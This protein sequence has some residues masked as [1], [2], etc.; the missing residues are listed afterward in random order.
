MNSTNTNA[1]G[2]D[3]SAMREFCNNRIYNAFPI[4]WKSIIKQVNI[5]ASAGNKSSE[6]ITSKDYVYLPSYTEMT[7]IV[8]GINYAVEGEHIAWFTSDTTRIKTRNGVVSKYGGRSPNLTY[9]SYFFTVM[10]DGY[11]NYFMSTTS[12]RGICQC[13][14]V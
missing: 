13:I 4:L 8:D 3:K 7:G 14:S 2:W 10:E 5:P 12:A 6:I 1:G 9:S 11:Y